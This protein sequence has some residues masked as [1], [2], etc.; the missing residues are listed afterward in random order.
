MIHNITQQTTVSFKTLYLN[1]FISRARGMIFRHFS[2]FDGVLF[3]NC[4]TVHTFFISRKLDVLFID[5][6][7]RICSLRERVSP[8]RPLLRDPNA[9]KVIELPPGTIANTN[10]TTGDI[11]TI[12]TEIIDVQSTTFLK[13]NIL[14]NTD[15]IIPFT[16]NQR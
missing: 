13:S 3:E 15:P 14:N 10:C 16:E 2:T 1:S 12:K 8:W 4:N 7:Q 6:L 5:D 9:V 11:L